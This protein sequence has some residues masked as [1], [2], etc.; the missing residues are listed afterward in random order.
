MKELK[1]HMT[2]IRIE[3]VILKAISWDPIVTVNT[4][5]VILGLGPSHSL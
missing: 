3:E 4:A 2:W 5:T 1:V